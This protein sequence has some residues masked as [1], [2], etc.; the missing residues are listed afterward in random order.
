M[1]NKLKLKIFLILAIMTTA[2]V[3]AYAQNPQWSLLS[4][5]GRTV[6]SSEWRGKFVVLSFGGTWVPL[7]TKELA[8]L[9][10]INERYST[11]GVLV[12]WV[13][14]NS[15]KQGS[16]TFA[17]ND[18]LQAFAQKNNVRLNI[19]RDPEQQ[20]YKALGLDAIP[21]VLII[22]RDGKV[23]RKHTG[24]GTDQGEGYSEIIRELEQ[25]LK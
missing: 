17:T 9:Q 18:D 4:T 1:V 13:S 16:R 10:K 5:D 2:S 21:T 11:R 12:Y 6:N 8:A 22:D 24:I 19:L 25:L 15:D 20:A 23:V 7:A 14:I 3:A